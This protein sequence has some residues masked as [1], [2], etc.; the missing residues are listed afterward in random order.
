MEVQVQDKKNQ[1]IL[2]TEEIVE[3]INKLGYGIDKSI[4]E[5]CESDIIVELYCSIFEKLGVLKRDKLKIRF[6]GMEKFSFPGMHDRPIYIL[7]LF[8]STKKFISDILGIENFTTADLFSPKLNRTKR[9]FS[10]IIKF[11]KFKQCEKET[12]T[13][14]KQNLDNSIS[15][16]KES[17][18]KFERA[19]SSYH[20]L[21]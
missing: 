5:N 12:Y 9:I 17:L 6:E 20:K 13:T 16:Y 18:N 4:I 19:E 7:K 3:F 2:K 21:K 8:N 11:Y 10:G 1:S 14:L 15:Q